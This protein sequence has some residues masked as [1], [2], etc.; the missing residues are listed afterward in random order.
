MASPRSFRRSHRRGVTLDMDEN[1]I[2]SRL[3]QLIIERDLECEKEQRVWAGKGETRPCTACMQPIST[4]AVEYEV[5]L[6]GSGK[7]LT[8][9]P[10]CH[11]IWLQ[12]CDELEFRTA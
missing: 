5:D 1:Y 2:R 7:R 9:H 8:F 11:S 3:R 4:T 6:N 10:R 12:V